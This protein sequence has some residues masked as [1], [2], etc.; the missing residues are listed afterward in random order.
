MWLLW[1]K[2]PDKWQHCIGVFFV[3]LVLTLPIF[4]C[5]RSTIGASN[6]QDAIDHNARFSMP[7]DS[8][9][10][11]RGRLA[12]GPGAGAPAHLRA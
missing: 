1:H 4:F 3:V 11:Y 12:V 9:P 2:L 5:S 7:V 10:D 6:S 8:C